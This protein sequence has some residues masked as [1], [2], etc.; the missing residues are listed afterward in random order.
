MAWFT[1][2]QIGNLYDFIAD[3]LEHDLPDNTEGD[4]SLTHPSG[5]FEVSA[6]EVEKS[7]TIRIDDREITIWADGELQYKRV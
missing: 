6:I 3:Y 2:L 1:K 5:R 7:V 4:V